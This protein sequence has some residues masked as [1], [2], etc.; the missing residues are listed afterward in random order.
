MIQRLQSDPSSGITG[1]K[2]DL[3]RRQHF[4]GLNQKP[5]M[6]LPSFGASLK[7]ALEERIIMILGI[8]AIFSIFFGLIYSPRTGWWPGASIFV[9]VLILVLITAIADY[10]KDKRFI[11]LKIQANESMVNVIRGRS[12]EVTSV[13]MWELCVGD[14]AKFGP[15][16][17]IPV[18]CI[19]VS[20]TCL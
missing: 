15:G 5:A 20:S 10:D 17:M 8:C 16:D 9:A 7:E 18:D 3:A 11:E 2:R 12:G 14:I 4:F 1:D 6:V 13:K 19:I